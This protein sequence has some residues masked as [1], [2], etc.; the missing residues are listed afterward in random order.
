MIKPKYILI[1][2]SLVVA[3]FYSCNRIEESRKPEV[4]NMILIVGNKSTLTGIKN[5]HN[6]Y[7]L[8][9]AN[10]I[11]LSFFSGGAVQ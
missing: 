1:A 5:N 7:E 8:S 9:K 2:F 11:V 4:K 3:A 6:F 10:Q